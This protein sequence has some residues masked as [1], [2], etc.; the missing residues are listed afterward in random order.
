MSNQTYYDMLGVSQTADTEIIHAAYQALTRKYATLPPN[1][2]AYMTSL[3]RQAYDVLSDPIKRADYDAWLRL[4]HSHNQP[5]GHY[6]PPSYTP[7]NHASSH[8]GYSHT[9][10]YGTA[11]A[12]PEYRT[13]HSTTKKSGSVMRWVLGL[14]IILAAVAALAYYLVSSTGFFGDNEAPV[15]PMST[16]QPNPPTTLHPIEPIA[17]AEPAAT[18][19]Q[20]SAR[21]QAHAEYLAAVGQ[22]NA[23]WNNLPKPLKDALRS[24][25]RSINNEREARCKAQAASQFTTA[26]EIETAR[27]LC[28]IPE[29]HARTQAL[30]IYAAEASYV[31]APVYDAYEVYEEPYVNDSSDPV[32]TMSTGQAKRIYDEAVANINGIWNGLPDETR[33][34]LRDEQRM[35]NAD[36]EARCRQYAQENYG[37]RSEQTIARYL[38]EAPQMDARAEELAAYY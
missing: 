24:E 1:D 38:C 25:Q 20:Q 12:R 4:N 18:P 10:N 28:E 33:E 34:A 6:T 32:Y 14:M 35:I 37:G 16:T 36:R 11:G 8:G 9:P 26:I 31:D 17:P 23:V 2:A 15:T 29:L 3:I 22:I 7:P 5:A 30:Q 19:E 13:A 27:Y 21:H